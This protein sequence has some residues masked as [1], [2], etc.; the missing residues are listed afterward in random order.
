MSSVSL[1]ASVFSIL[2]SI[3]FMVQSIISILLAKSISLRS[4]RQVTVF[5][6]N[7]MKSSLILGE[8]MSSMSILTS[9][10]MPMSIVYYLKPTGYWMNRDRISEII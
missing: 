1:F 6:M 2:H 4:E 8:L 5:S 9:L 10:Q 3:I 7:F